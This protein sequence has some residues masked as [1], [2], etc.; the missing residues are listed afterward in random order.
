MSGEAL[1]ADKKPATQKSSA[2]D[3]ATTESPTELTGLPAALVQRAQAA[4]RTLTP[5][6]IH[7]LQR[8]VGNQAV[9]RLLGQQRSAPFADSGSAT[10]VQRKP[11]VVD[12][13][14]EWEAGPTGTHGAAGQAR[15][16][17][18]SGLA[19]VVQAKPRADVSPAARV[20]KIPYANVFSG[21][22]K[23]QRTKEDEETLQD[24]PSHGLVGGEVDHDVAQSIQRAKGGGQPLHEG[25]RS[26]MGQALGADFSRVRVHTGR[27]ADVLNRSLNARAFTTG[28]DVFFSRGAYNPGTSSGSKLLAHE[29]THV[30]QQGS[31][32]ATVQRKLKFGMGDLEGYVSTKAAYKGKVGFSSTYRKIEKALTRYWAAD[33]GDERLVQ[34]RVLAA[35]SQK[36]LVDYKQDKNPSK[37]DREKMPS[38][39]KLAAAVQVELQ[40]EEYKAK[41]GSHTPDPDVRNSLLEAHG[42]VSLYGF[43]RLRKKQ[44]KRGEK[45]K[46]E[47]AEDEMDLLERYESL[48]SQGL[49]QAE[50]FALT[51]YTGHQYKLMNPAMAGDKGWFKGNMEAPEHGKDTSPEKVDKAMEINQEI[52]G[53]AVAGLSKLPPW[54]QDRKLY[55]GETFP[56]AEGEALG[57]GVEKTYPHFVSTSQERATP[58]SMLGE[59][60]SESRPYKVLFHITKTYRPGKDVSAVSKQGSGE[61]EILF[62]A[63]TTLAVTKTLRDDQAANLKEVEA[64]TK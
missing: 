8:T 27:Q 26:S 32:S 22:A 2:L 61:A 11:D 34:L 30:V 45:T 55:R 62:P 15:P 47:V 37:L 58:Y 24:A 25:V 36:W 18:Q 35:M 4:A 48:K 43:A 5:A 63:G 54:K 49:S 56:Q 21:T 20:S 64:V 44:L 60:A 42:G 52:A 3:S 13:R 39:S 38:I 14:D 7:H 17:A 53:F 1:A 23:P 46:D 28:R 40:D 6:D 41:F 10:T 50:I 9:A 57:P 19:A 33:T 16:F 59:N 29:L 31:A 51:S 12:K